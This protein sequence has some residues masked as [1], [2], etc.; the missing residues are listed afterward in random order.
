MKEFVA[1]NSRWRVAFIFLGAAGFVALGLW[2]VGAFGDVPSS[3]RHSAGYTITIG[4]LCISFFGLCAV[5][6]VKR[7]FDRRAQLQ[8]GPSGIVWSPWSDKLIP[9]SEITDITTWSYKG[10]K[11]IILHLG[12]PDHF[13]GRGLAA[14]LAGANQKLTGGDISIS[15]TGTNRNYESALSAIAEFR[16]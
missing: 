15:L 12:N 11:A 6:M 10:Q 1:Y 7:L 8:I 13:P 3:L 5:A 14:K 9:W 16:A 4:W 2:M